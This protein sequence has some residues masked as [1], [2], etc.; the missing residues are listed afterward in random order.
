MTARETGATCPDCGNRPLT[1][2]RT[3]GCTNAQ[4]LQAD[5]LRRLA[6]R[7]GER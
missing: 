1:E 4:H 5:S 6:G 3:V 2:P 7:E